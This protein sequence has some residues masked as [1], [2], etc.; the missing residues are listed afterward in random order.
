MTLNMDNQLSTEQ[1]ILIIRNGLEKSI[2]PKNIIIV[3]A[4]LSGLVSASLLK[5]IVFPKNAISFY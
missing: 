2:S 1:M 3:G 4:G 5:K